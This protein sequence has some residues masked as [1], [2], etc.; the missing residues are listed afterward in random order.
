VTDVALPAARRHVAPRGRRV[1]MW[2]GIHS[3]RQIAGYAQ[4][5]CP[6][7]SEVSPLQRIIAAPPSIPEVTN[8]R[9]KPR[10]HDEPC[11]SRPVV[12][13]PFHHNGLDLEEKV[14]GWRMLGNYKRTRLSPSEG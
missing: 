14:D 5:A 2:I 9:T 7:S 6:G 11:L 13:G 1:R 12:L 4:Q 8:S 3:Q 10:D